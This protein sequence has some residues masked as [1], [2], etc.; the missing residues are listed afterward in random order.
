MRAHGIIFSAAT[1]VPVSSFPFSNKIN[2][3]YRF[4]Y[5]REGT[6]ELTFDPVTHER[7]I[8]MSSKVES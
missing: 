4:H 2:A 1:G 7:A 3:L 6:A 8:E 5:Q